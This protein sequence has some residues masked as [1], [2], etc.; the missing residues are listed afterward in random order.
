MGFAGD[1]ERLQD[2]LDEF[3]ERDP[4]MERSLELFEE[5][6]TL[7]KGCREFLENAKRRVTILAGDGAAEDDFPNERTE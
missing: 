2:I 7:I 3:E 1:M 6:V 5:G 4:D